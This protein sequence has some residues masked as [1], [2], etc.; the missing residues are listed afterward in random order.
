LK[1]SPVKHSGLRSA[2]NSSK[3]SKIT[4][5]KGNDN[6]SNGDNDEE[7]DKFP[8][9]VDGFVMGSRTSKKSIVKSDYDL[10]S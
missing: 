4:F 1:E 6:D 10:K 8:E 3:P 5:P 2:R 7:L 9:E